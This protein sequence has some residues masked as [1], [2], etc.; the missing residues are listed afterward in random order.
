[1]RAIVLGTSNL[2]RVAGVIALADRAV[3]G[4]AGAL[5]RKLCDPSALPFAADAFALLDFGSGST[6]FQLAIG[7]C[8]FVLRVSRRSLGRSVYEQ[9]AIAREYKRNYDVF[10]SYYNREMPLAC[11]S[12]C[13][14]LNG[15]ILGRPVF[16]VLQP[17]VA[18]TKRDALALT[19][20]ELLALLARHPRLRAAFAAFV[21]ATEALIAERNKCFDLLGRSNLILAGDHDPR[22]VIVDIGMFSLDELRTNHPAK[23]DALSQVRARLLA[24][25]AKAG[26]AS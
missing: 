18:G 24:L 3:P 1:L 22:L 4:A 14:L 15:P 16:A 12:D 11:R 5:S 20:T 7:E 9:L 23:L 6:V 8:D 2:H 10:V 13:L 17:F 19:D 26:A 21:R 25:D